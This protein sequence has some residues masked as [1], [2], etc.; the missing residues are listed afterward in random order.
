M[1]IFNI[2]MSE[3]FDKEFERHMKK[4]EKKQQAYSLE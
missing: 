1:F 3:S 4:L 2:P